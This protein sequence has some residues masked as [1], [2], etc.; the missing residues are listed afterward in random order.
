V[1]SR[2][3]P[4]AAFAAL[5]V[6]VPAAAAQTQTETAT[7]G[8]V[9][10]TLSYD[11]VQDSFEY[12]NMQLAIAR[13]GTQVFAADPTFGDC[14]SPFCAPAGQGNRDSVVADDLD[15]DGEPE[16]IVDLYTG[17]AHCCYVSR[18]YRWNGTAYVPSDRNFGDPGYNVADLDGDGVKELITADYRFGYAF[19]AFAFSLMPV[20][21]YDLR[22]GRWEVVTTRFPDRIRKDARAAWK[23][24]T[25]I[26]RQEEPRGAI[27]AWAADQL[28]LGKRKS[29]THTLNR[30]ARQGR[31]P[32]DGFPPKGQR[33]FVR[34][35]LRFLAKRGY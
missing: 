20:R 26:S 25:K 17:G 22:A 1:R 9:S 4:L 23:T 13:G 14:D 8:A 3:A 15:G 33:K 6:L 24:F 34:N 11:H 10:A 32:G 30:L 29:A 2:S 31:L 18:F 19:S 12:K 35:L 7:A 16:V 5:A 21:I 28:M 27:A